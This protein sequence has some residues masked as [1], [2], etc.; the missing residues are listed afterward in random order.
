MT[1]RAGA[2]LSAA[3]SAFRWP[4]LEHAG[5]AGMRTQVLAGVLMGLVYLVGVGLGIGPLLTAMVAVAASVAVLWPMAGLSI[6]VLIMTSR[7]PAILVPLYVNATLLAAIGVGCFF[8]LSGDRLS[9]RMHPAVA[10]LIGFAAYTAL[11][12]PPAISGYPGDWVPTAIL[13][14]VKLMS[15]P[16]LF[17]IAMYI[18]RRVPAGQYVAVAMLG[19]AMMTLLGV[20]VA[21][22]LPSSLV[23]DGLLNP[24]RGSRAVGGFGSANY[25]GFFTA[26]AL[27]LAAGLWLAL[28]RYR[29]VLTIV[30]AIFAAGLL[31]SFSRSSY[32]ASLIGL[33]VILAL[34]DRRWA[35]AFAVVA[36]VGAAVVYPLFLEARIGSDVLDPDI[37]AERVLSDTW[38]ARAG[39]AGI[40]MWST[41][42]WFGV[43]FGVHQNI[44]PAF[45]GASPATYT[46]NQFVAFLAEQG[47]VG[48]VMVVGLVAALAVAL[49]RS[50]S[51]FR[52]AALAMGVA[53]LIQSNFINS[54]TSF[55]ISGLTW[56]AMAAALSAAPARAPDPRS[57]V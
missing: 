3:P 56:L 7:E 19:A 38:R 23:L 42:P 36:A 55:D 29:V 25:F 27:L 5:A 57:E 6:L 53:Y 14:F 54:A 1:S 43:G 37:I 10:L 18:F 11:S 32:I 35:M 4:T 24:E 47:I 17:L 2:A 51:P 31:L 9:V 39:L 46:H 33:G 30:V 41:E 52:S 16:A 8:R 48:V 44:S 15:S 34:R 12:I 40:Q 45:I 26:Q 50:S 22:D 13:R 49:W 28:P 20:A 21:L